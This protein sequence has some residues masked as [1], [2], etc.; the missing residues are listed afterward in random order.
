METIKYFFKKHDYLKLDLQHLGLQGGGWMIKI[1]N[2]TWNHTTPVF[3]HYILD[4]EID[5]L[6]G[7]ITFEVIIM[8]P[9]LE[10]W[11]E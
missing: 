2:T 9:I 5:A 11:N 1:Y 10:W 7:S 4:E 3:K 6:V 8:T